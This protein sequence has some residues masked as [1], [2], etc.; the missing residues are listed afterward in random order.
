MKNSILYGIIVAKNPD[1]DPLVMLC[2]GDT[3]EFFDESVPFDK[4]RKL[5]VEANECKFLSNVSCFIF[6]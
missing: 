1:K 3:E 2:F 6:V 5:M 4:L